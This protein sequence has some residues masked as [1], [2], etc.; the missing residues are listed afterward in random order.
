MFFSTSFRKS[1]RFVI[2]NLSDFDTSQHL[3]SFDRMSSID[4][5]VTMLLRDF[6]HDV[7]A[8]ED[9]IADAG[10][11]DVSVLLCYTRC[12]SI[13]LFVPCLITMQPAIDA[14]LC[15]WPIEKRSLLL[16]I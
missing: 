3:V 4:K 2:G 9:G 12:V 14:A 5:S 7:S 11:R 10:N 8:Y 13:Q 15:S 6:V 1:L 16:L